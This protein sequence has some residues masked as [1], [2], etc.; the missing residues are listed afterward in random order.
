[1]PATR[2]LIDGAQVMKMAMWFSTAD[3]KRQLAMFPVYS[4]LDV[5][6]KRYAGESYM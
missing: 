1:M 3:H 2:A 4:Q 5:Y 6:F